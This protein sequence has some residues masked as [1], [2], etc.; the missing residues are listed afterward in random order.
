[1][2][3][4]V[5]LMRI[6][7]VVEMEVPQLSLVLRLLM[8]VVVQ[9]VI[10]MLAQPLQVEQEVEV[11]EVQQEKMLEGVVLTTMA[12]EAVVLMGVDEGDMVVQE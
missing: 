8:L 3:A 12:V 7:V 2:L 1:M 6:E 5:I 9:E 11:Q 10:V 4:V